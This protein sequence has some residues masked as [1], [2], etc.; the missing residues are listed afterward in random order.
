MIAR[1][2]LYRVA[3]FGIGSWICLGLTAPMASANSIPEQ[4]TDAQEDSQDTLRQGLP[5][6]RLGGGTRSVSVLS[7]DCDCLAA[8]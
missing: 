4:S 6:R 3:L 1:K 5:G 7:D 8:D 2:Y